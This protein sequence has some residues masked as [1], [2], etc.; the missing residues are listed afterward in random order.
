MG[1]NGLLYTVPAKSQ[2][3]L[4]IKHTII[5]WVNKA[6]FQSMYGSVTFLLHFFHRRNTEQYNINDAAEMW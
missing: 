4:V 3:F 2:R 1:R 5:I 6:S